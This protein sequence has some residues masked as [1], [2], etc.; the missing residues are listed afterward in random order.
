MFVLLSILREPGS[1]IV[2]LGSY[3][4]PEIGSTSFIQL[5]VGGGEPEASQ[6]RSARVFTGRVW[7]AG[8]TLMMG[9]G[10]SA[11]AVTSR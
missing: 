11:M 9:G 2:I 5:T 6:G 1:L 8:P 4:R 7:L 3:C 10:S